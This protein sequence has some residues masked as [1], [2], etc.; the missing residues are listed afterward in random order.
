MIVTDYCM[1]FSDE[2]LT[3][4]FPPS[5]A[6]AFFEALFGDADEG[7]FDIALKFVQ[8]DQDNA[9]LHFEL[10]LIERPGKCL[11][12]NLTYG[13]PTVFARHPII[14]IKGVVKEIEHHIDSPTTQLGNWQLGHT[15]TVNSSLHIIPLTITLS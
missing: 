6:N 2:I 3:E 1:L 15:R 14:D 12:C 8:H 11:A 5:R 7:A 10:H 9:M 13:M 4:I